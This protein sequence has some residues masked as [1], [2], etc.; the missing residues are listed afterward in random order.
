M[1]RMPKSLVCAFA[2]VA[3]VLAPVA[4]Q[5]PLFTDAFPIAEFAGR[6]A[7]VM[8]QIGDGV[9]IITGA[10]ERADY[11]K[12]KQNKQFFYL[13]G[14]EVPRAMLLIDGKT[15]SSTLFLPAR[16]DANDRSEGPLL[17]PD[18]TAKRLTGIETVADRATFDEAIKKI[19]A[20]GR[21]IY[22]PFR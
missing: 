9:A 17:R 12:F 10:T 18:D 3:V 22:V 14:V 16:T 20:E 21:H 4:A 5:K 2:L 15:K 6:R 8:K 7:E 19:A 13:S 11:E 1:R